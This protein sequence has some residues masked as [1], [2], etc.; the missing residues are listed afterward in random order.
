MAVD[1]KTVHRIARLARLRIS[2]DE[3]T[4]LKGELNAMLKWV[5]QLNE[6]DTS[7]VPPMSRIVDMKLRQR[8]DQ[9]TD[10]DKA[11]DVIA[12]APMSD[13]HCFVVPKVVE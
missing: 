10:G 2:E 12:N 7:D 1:E 9:V 11:D 5:E 13:D 6:V 8:E 3:A 4:H